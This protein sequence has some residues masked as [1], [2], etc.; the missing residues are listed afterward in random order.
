MVYSR[1][2]KFS[3]AVTSRATAAAACPWHGP[4]TFDRI[5]VSSTGL[6]D[7]TVLKRAQDST[8]GAMVP[9]EAS[10]SD[11]LN[12]EGYWPIETTSVANYPGIYCVYSVSWE[13]DSSRLLYIG[14]ARNISNA[15]S[16][17]RGA[18]AEDA[19]NDL[20]L[21]FN[22]CRMVDKKKRVEAKAALIHHHQPP[23]NT[24]FKRRFPYTTRR[25]TTIGK[26]ANLAPG[27]VAIEYLS[28]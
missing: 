27:F 12:F 1:V 18:L 6:E 2:C 13:N 7:I 28:V 14:E 19:R 8:V 26:N 23:R 11:V 16:R 3:L 25:V 5:D 4:A 20:S 22:A 24:E 21:Y 10:M 15:A 9:M 17:R